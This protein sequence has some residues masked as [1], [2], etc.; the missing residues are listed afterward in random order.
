MRRGR[1]H[2]PRRPDPPFRQPDSARE[3][4][5][6]RRLEPRPERKERKA[7]DASKLPTN[8]DLKTTAARCLRDVWPGR[9]PAP[10]ETLRSCRREGV[11]NRVIDDQ[12]DHRDHRADD[13]LD[14]VQDCPSDAPLR[15]ELSVVSTDSSRAALRLGERLPHLLGGRA[16]R[17]RISL[18]EFLEDAGDSQIRAWDDSIPKIQVEVGEVVE[19][20]ELARQYTA[21]LEYELP[22]DLVG[23]T[24]C[25]LSTALSSCSSSRARPSLSRPTSTRQR[26]TH[27]TCAATTSTAPTARCTRSWC[28]RVRTATRV[29]A[30]A[31]TSPAR[32]PC[33]ASFRSCSGRGSKG[34]SP[35]MSSLPRTP[36]ARFPHSC[37]RPASSSWT[38]RSDRS[39]A[40]WPRPNRPSMRFPTLLTR[41]PARGLGTSCSSPAFRDPARRWWA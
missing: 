12:H 21:I 19:I 35:P 2:Q 25:S 4:I 20:D 14:V 27:A 5:Q 33:T 34:R 15:P 13:Q 24:S 16:A 3:A 17:G 11:V 10:R 41:Q 36:T 31:C 18:Q 32:I 38:A 29:Y 1:D 6:H 8:E 39:T 30:T 28:P 9:N 37:R 22:L 40:P 26:H 23:P 7:Y